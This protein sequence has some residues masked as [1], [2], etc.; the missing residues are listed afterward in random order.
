MTEDSL[1]ELLESGDFDYVSVDEIGF[2]A[3]VPGFRRQ[4]K[5]AAL[6]A[7]EELFRSG[8]ME[9]GDISGSGFV[10][11][12]GGAE[13]WVVRA[14]AELSQLPWMPHSAGFWMNLTERG[15]ERLAELRGKREG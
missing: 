7:M 3:D 4:S 15:A 6:A 8:L 5:E 13:A 10:V 11:W 14:R 9:P 12:P 2:V 1:L